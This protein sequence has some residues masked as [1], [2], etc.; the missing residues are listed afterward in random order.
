MIKPILE[1]TIV[2][3]ILPKQDMGKIEIELAV[4]DRMLLNLH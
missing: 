3:G 2:H 1:N 4:Q